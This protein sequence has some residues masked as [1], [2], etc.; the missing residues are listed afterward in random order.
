MTAVP[1]LR[2]KGQDAVQE[3]LECLKNRYQVLGV[4]CQQE[5]FGV[6]C[7]GRNES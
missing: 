3:V 1:K 6:E 5:G 7:Q 2:G 4:G